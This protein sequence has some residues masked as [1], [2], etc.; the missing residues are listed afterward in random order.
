MKLNERERKAIELLYVEMH[1]QL[2]R[3]ARLML[4]SNSL[5]EEAVQEA[6]RIACGK[7]ESLLS[8]ENPHGWMMLT[9]L[10]T[11]KNMRRSVQKLNDLV[12]YVGEYWEPADGAEIEL[13][14]ALQ[15]D[16]VVSKEDFHL[17]YLVAVEGYSILEAAQQV[18]LSMEACK[19]RIQR[20]KKKLRDKI[21]GTL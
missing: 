20:A 3:C 17:L 7:P 14:L 13:D 18:G 12:L 9:L 21:K 10:N 8:S 5:A 2:F 4:N 15:Y 11:A 6:F 19:K 1:D 16:G